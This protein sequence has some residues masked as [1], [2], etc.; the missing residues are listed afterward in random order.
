MN[1]VNKLNEHNSF[2]NVLNLKSI[3][4]LFIVIKINTFMNKSN[5]ETL[6]YDSVRAIYILTKNCLTSLYLTLH[7]TL[8]VFQQVN[9]HSI[10]SLC[11]HNIRFTLE[12]S[13]RVGSNGLV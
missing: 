4:D 11:L 5:L 10:P 6:E 8:S 13:K 2:I 9:I 1:E 12:L 7:Y 3:L